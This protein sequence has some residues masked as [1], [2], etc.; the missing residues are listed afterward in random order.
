MKKN[1]ILPYKEK[2]KKLRMSENNKRLKK[3]PDQE[4]LNA[5]D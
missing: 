3:S 2:L 5:E 4:G 1:N